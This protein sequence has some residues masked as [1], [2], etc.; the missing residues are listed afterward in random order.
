[1]PEPKQSE[2]PESPARLE[3]QAMAVGAVLL[4]SAL[5]TGCATIWNPQLWWD[6]TGGQWI[7]AAREMPDQSPLGLLADA[8]RP[9]GWLWQVMVYVASRVLGIGGLVLVKMALLCGTVAAALVRPL[10][11][12][13]A[14]WSGLVGLLLLFA[15]LGQLRLGSSL[16]A[17]LV[18]ALLAGSLHRWLQRPGSR[19]LW[20]WPVWQWAWVNLDASWP[21]GLV[22]IF[23]AGAA[24]ALRVRRSEAGRYGRQV[25]ASGLLAAFATLLTPWLLEVYAATGAVWGQWLSGAHPAAYN[26]PMGGQIL[27]HPGA[28]VLFVLAAVVMVLRGRAVP[29]THWI[30]LV[31]S[32]LVAGAAAGN[33]PVSCPI[34]AILAGLHGADLLGRI[35][36]ARPRRR[37]IPPAVPSG[38][39]AGAALLLVYLSLSGWLYARGRTLIRPGLGITPERFATA[40]ADYL[41]QLPAGG[42]V[43]CTDL[44]DAGVFAWQMRPRL[45]PNRRVVIDA[46]AG[47]YDR[48]DY[49]RH[50]AWQSRLRSPE[51]WQTDLPPS[52]RFV[53]VPQRDLAT[54]ESLAGS[55]QFDAIHLSPAGVLFAVNNWAGGY[56]NW[57]PTDRLASMPGAPQRPAGNIARLLLDLTAEPPGRLMP[58]PRAAEGP[59][60]LPA[61]VPRD[62]ML[63]TAALAI[64]RGAG[65]RTDP[66]MP[67]D[68]KGELA[69]L[70]AIQRLRRAWIQSGVPW[71]FSRGSL[72]RALLQRSR[73]GRSGD[74]AVPIDREVID[75]H[76][77]WALGHFEQIHP[78]DGLDPAGVTL[79]LAHVRALHE[80]GYLEMARDRMERLFEQLGPRMRAE[81]P[82]MLTALRNE[83][84]EQVAESIRLSRS[85]RIRRMGIRDRAIALAS[86]PLGLKRRAIQLLGENPS[87]DTALLLGDL[88]AQLGRFDQAAAV[89]ERIGPSSPHADG[90]RAR[91]Q[92]LRPWPLAG[93][94]RPAQLPD[95]PLGRYVAAVQLELLGRLGQ[96]LSV[97]PAASPEDAVLAGRI[98]RLGQRLGR[99]MLLLEAP[100]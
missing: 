94:I 85:G 86:P 19:W 97:L 25:L 1:M 46:R 49:A 63:G 76:L 30:W 55:W 14:W 12:R 53:Y 41:G 56:E 60:L 43:Y 84:R 80:A 17:G 59:T 13:P 57:A 38:V 20:T 37:R 96:A 8:W 83:L 98:D 9:V 87:P 11:R 90:V 62:Y 70:V 16:A 51:A 42:D 45:Q 67:G 95:A 75:L 93:D 72:A 39:V 47:L 29:P 73:Q 27:R 18:A 69:C 35:G 71:L 23:S 32:G 6:L 15:V 78:A 54:V 10:G 81:P 50:A 21:L 26:Q 28:V 68:A 91:R 24:W 100:G 58:V 48:Q 88:L 99:Q 82:A 3:P 4:L 31:G 34:W 2:S 77:A 5:A 61:P 22:M 7:L 36:Q 79:S 66:G 64:A 74:P 33:L 92:V 44:T 65:R 52:V 40:A 89:W